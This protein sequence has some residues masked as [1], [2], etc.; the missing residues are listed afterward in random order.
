MRR[1]LYPK[2]FASI[3]DLLDESDTIPQDRKEILASLTNY[4]KSTESPKLTFVCT[5]NSRRSHLAQAW[6]WAAAMYF[7]KPNVMVYSGGTEATALYPQAG[8]ALKDAGFE[9]RVGPELRNP[10]HVLRTG[11]HLPDI[12]L[13]SKKF[14]DAANPSSDFCVV[15][16]CSEAEKECPFV[17]GASHRVH[18]PYED[19]KAFDDSPKKA[20]AY[21]ERS[22]QIGRELL[23]AFQQAYG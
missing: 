13:F 23:W 11:G 14:D 8:A 21:L 18:L 6:A 12:T 15:T 9:I 1:Q 20:V 3:L 5:H 2:L 10:K 22:R 19:P 4:L 17:P 7:E 16:V